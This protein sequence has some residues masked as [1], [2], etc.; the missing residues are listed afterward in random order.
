M[1]R[2]PDVVARDVVGA[3]VPPTGDAVAPERGNTTTE[4]RP[5]G[6]D[7]DRL[8]ATFSS[9]SIQSRSVKG[10]TAHTVV[11]ES[12]CSTPHRAASVAT[13]DRPATPR[14]CRPRLGDQRLGW[15]TA[16]GDRDLDTVLADA[17][18]DRELPVCERARVQHRVADQFGRDQ[19]RPLR[20]RVPARRQDHREAPLARTRRWQALAIRA[21][22]SRP[23][24]PRQNGQ[25]LPQ[26]RPLGRRSVAGVDAERAFLRALTNN[27]RRRPDDRARAW[28]RAESPAARQRHLEAGAPA[29]PRECSNG[30]A[31]RLKSTAARCRGRDPRRR[32][33]AAHHR[34]GRSAR[35]PGRVHQP[36]YRGRG[37]RPAR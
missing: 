13:I 11:D 2:S 8:A 22:N 35:T 36:G 15:G 20:E 19:A 25:N 37:R 26:H 27:T 21:E 1:G 3:R 4:A 29:V 28:E 33:A 17:P 18:G 24:V 9:R 14:V 16:V 6:V 10:T 30:A 7:G 34:L 12:C 23:Y 31:V 32:I 5:P